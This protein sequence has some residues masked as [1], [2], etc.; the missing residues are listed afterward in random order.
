M[1]IAAIIVTIIATLLYIVT[2]NLLINDPIGRS[3]KPGAHL[4]NFFM[5]YTVPIILW[6]VYYIMNEIKKPNSKVPSFTNSNSKTTNYIYHTHINGTTSEPLTYNQLQAKNI[7]KDTY[8]W[9]NGI[10]WIKAGDLKELTPLFEPNGPPPFVEPKPEPDFMDKYTNEIIFV[11][12]LVTI[13]LF[14]IMGIRIYHHQ[15]KSA[16]ANIACNIT[17]MIV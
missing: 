1:K 6:V 7:T 15:S 12:I 14:I 2:T 9:R 5:W 4:F 13:A 10:D 3:D 11:L 8:V 16:A 17:K